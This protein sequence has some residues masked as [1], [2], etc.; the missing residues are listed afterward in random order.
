MLFA[1]NM[2]FSL[3]PLLSQGA[4]EAIEAHGSPDQRAKYLERL[5]TGEWSGTMNLT[6]SGAGSDLGPMKTR[7]EREG[8]HYR[9][10]GQK[11]YITYGEHDMSE[12]IIHLVLARLPDAPAGVKG[13]SLFLVPKFIPNENNEPGQRNGVR[14]NAIEEKMG[15]HGNATCQLFFDGAVGW[16]VGQP[17][18]GLAA[19]FTMMNAARLGVGSPVTLLGLLGARAPHVAALRG[20]VAA[21][22]AG[23][24]ASQRVRTA[25]AGADGARAREAEQAVAAVALAPSPPPPPMIYE[26]EAAAAMATLAGACEHHA[27]GPIATTS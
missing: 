4:I 15:I 8:G 22:L 6:E 2:S 20:R 14:C 7:A 24:E 5:V 3:C 12:N 19:M 11:I 1:A 23:G 16:M 9:I 26:A 27:R 13:I 25:A 10:F 21:E 18:K 17:N